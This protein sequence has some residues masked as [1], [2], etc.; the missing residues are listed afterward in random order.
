MRRNGE[1]PRKGELSRA[2]FFGA[3]EQPQPKGNAMPTIPSSQRFRKA[4]PCPICHGYDQ[5]PRG[6]GKRCYGFLSDDGRFAH[7]TRNE[8]AGR[9]SKNADSDTYAH[10]LTGNCLCGV[11][12]DPNPEDPSR[13]GQGRRIIATYDYTDEQGTLLYQAVRYHPKGFSQRRPNG[14]GGWI[15]NLTGVRLVLFRLPQIL[16]AVKAGRMIFAV[17]GEEDV[18]VLV[19]LGLDATTNPMG[20]KKWRPHFS[21]VLRGAHVVVLGDNDDDGRAHRAQV[22][23]SLHGK[24]ASLKAPDLPGLP[25]H[26]DIRDWL[27]AGHTKEDLLTLVEQAPIIQAEDFPSDEGEHQEHDEDEENPWRHIK[28][29]PTFLAEP[30]PE[31]EG[32][33]KDLL[34]P[35]AITM[36]AAPRGLG[37]TH[38][39]HALGVALATGGRFRGQPV[40]PVRVLL[41]DR[42]N[43]EYLIKERLKAWGAETAKN[44]HILTRQYAP[45]LN[46]QQAWAQFPVKDFEAIIL[47]AVGSFTEGIT[48][49]EGKQTTEVLATIVDL[50]RKDLGV[51]L[52]QNATKDGVNFKGREEWADRVDVIYELRDATDFTPSTKKPWWEE[53]PEAHEGA[54]AARA[55]RRKGRTDFRL[56]FVPTKYRLGPEPEPFCLE[57]NLPPDR[58]WT[59]DDVTEKLQQAG[60]RAKAEAEQAQAQQ[61]DD[62]AQALADL[63]AEREAEGNPLLKTDAETFLCKEQELKRA[64]ARQIIKGKTGVLWNIG[65]A[66][67]GRGK[68]K[69]Q[70]LLPANSPSSNTPGVIPLNDG[71]QNDLLGALSDK[72]SRGTLS[73]ALDGSGRQTNQPYNPC[74]TSPPEDGFVC[75]GGGVLEGH[76]EKRGVEDPSSVDTNNGHHPADTMNCP[77]CGRP[78]HPKH[79]RC[80]ECGTR[81]PGL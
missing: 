18:K 38:L 40:K 13:K 60:E 55:A 8:Y 80:Y 59:V 24:A 50:A 58:P 32:L 44:L 6:Q 61:C 79:P 71:K 76:S 46:K 14:Q 17:E 74:D 47:D 29:A 62:A 26:G 69:S 33:A 64:D 30:S 19:K 45:S 41:L 7:C 75:R 31:F 70:T 35:G 51:L 77:Q 4:H 1:G 81:R 52:L 57:L 53:L 25:V 12:H 28:D 5:A 48:E 10:K 73:A 22:L 72:G 36:L 9:L 65:P 54:W 2:F 67:S 20:A 15:W 42:D 3:A 66:P 78:L 56:A 39:G 34:A 21:E 23:R 16:D 68:G 11:R 37:K 63:V 27:K 49:K 43:P